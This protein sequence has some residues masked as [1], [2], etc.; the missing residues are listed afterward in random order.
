MQHNI[1]VKG[2]R[3][4]TIRRSNG[5]AATQADVSRKDVG[6]PENSLGI[7]AAGLVG[8]FLDVPDCVA[9]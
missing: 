5:C 9:L 2:K 1:W 8:E 6:M 3:R 7:A 4:A